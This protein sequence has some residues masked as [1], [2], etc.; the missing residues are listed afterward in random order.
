MIAQD[1][2]EL[3]VQSALSKV[4]HGG[5]KDGWGLYDGGWMA[6]RSIGVRWPYASCL[7]VRAQHALYYTCGYNGRWDLMIVPGFKELPDWARLVQLMD[8]KRVFMN[9]VEFDLQQDIANQ[10]IINMELKLSH[11]RVV[12]IL[13]NLIEFEFDQAAIEIAND[14]SKSVLMEHQRDIRLFG[15]SEPSDSSA[16]SSKRRL[17]ARR[18]SRTDSTCGDT[19][20][21]VRVHARTART[22]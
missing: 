6:G 21:S 14:M 17:E 9:Y 4:K 22:V 10:K 20:Q 3:W 8:T 1:F 11:V 13:M 5:V 18:G 2:A 15:H 12:G 16:P 7:R 19:V